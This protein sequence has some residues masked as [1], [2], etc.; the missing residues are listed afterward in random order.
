MTTSFNKSY[1]ETWIL[2]VEEFDGIESNKEQELRIDFS[3]DKIKN[4]LVNSNI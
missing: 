2:Q 4:W 3:L 1:A